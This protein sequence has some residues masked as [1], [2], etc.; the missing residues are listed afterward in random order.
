MND[1]LKITGH[2]QIKKNG[3][4]VRDISNLVVTAGKT[5]IADL[6]QAGTGIP[7][8][9]MAVGTGTT[10]ANA[11]DTTLETEAARVALST[12]GGTR[13]ANA[14]EFEG[15]YP[16]GTGTGA[17]TEAGILN[18]STGGTMLARTVFAAVSKGA[19]D[20]L[21]ITWTVTVG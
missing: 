9:H 7:M 4:V 13:T 15:I 11:A 19:S 10:A 1:N 5:W 2:L 12:A 8:S 14:I 16:A 20:A 18:D 6:M 17:L 3:E 21:T